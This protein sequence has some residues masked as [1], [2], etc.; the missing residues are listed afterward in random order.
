MDHGRELQV[1]HGRELQVDHGRELQVVNYKWI[2]RRSK[3][4]TGFSI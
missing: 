2:I 3:P 4:V 1:D